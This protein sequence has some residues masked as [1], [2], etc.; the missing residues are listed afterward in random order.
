MG[1]GWEGRGRSVKGWSGEGMGG[2][3]CTKGRDGSGAEWEE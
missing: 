1:R 3:E 2:E